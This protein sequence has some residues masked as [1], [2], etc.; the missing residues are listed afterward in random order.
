[1][2]RNSATIMYNQVNYKETREQNCQKH[3]QVRFANS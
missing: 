2:D 3:V 1:M